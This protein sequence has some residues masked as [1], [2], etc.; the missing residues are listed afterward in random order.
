MHPPAGLLARRPGLGEG[1]GQL[2]GRL[3]DRAPHHLVGGEQPL[4]GPVQAFELLAGDAA[5]AGQVG[6]HP[7]AHRLGLADQPPALLAGGG[8]DLL[9]RRLGFGPGQL[10]LGDHAVALL[11][12]RAAHLVDDLLPL[13]PLPLDLG[14]RLAAQ[15]VGLG[16]D[17]GPLGRRLGLGLLDDGAGFR[18][19]LAHHAGGGLL[20]LGADVGRRRPGRVEHPGGLLAQDLDQPVLV[21][22]LGAGGPLL[23][24]LG[25]LPLVRLAALQPPDQLR[26]LVEERPDLLRVVALADRRELPA[27]DA[28]RVVGRLRRHGGHGMTRRRLALRVDP[29]AA[30]RGER[31]RRGRPSRPSQPTGAAAASPTSGSSSTL[32]PCSASTARASSSES[33]ATTSRSS[34]ACSTASS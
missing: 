15:R 23:G 24:P 3:V 9:G 4:P 14:L 17:L 25:P 10:A 22:L 34:P 20:G 32:P 12:G 18:L 2:V 26:D 1:D 19:R 6:E 28:R 5:P 13:G 8:P 31:A 33:T 16:Q 7:L 11:L 30:E 27:G 29:G 21:E